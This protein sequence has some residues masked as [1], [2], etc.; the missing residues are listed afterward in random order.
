MPQ[1]KPAQAP[2]RFTLRPTAAA[3]GS[4]VLAIAA[5]AAQAQQA[6]APAPAAQTSLGTVTVTGIR[7]AIENAINVKKQSDSIV[8]SV[9]AEDIGKLP[10]TS[11]AESVAR[12]PGVAAQRGG[13]RVLGGRS[14]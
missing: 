6:P 7:R 8:E 1:R 9:T 10:D 13:G 2:G 14:P 3:A 12:L 11:I 4:V 5:S